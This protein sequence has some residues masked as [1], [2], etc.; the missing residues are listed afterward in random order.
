MMIQLVPRSK[1]PASRF[2]TQSLFRREVIAFF[3]LRYME[4]HKLTLWAGSRVF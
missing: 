4:T 3:F 1:H 2:K